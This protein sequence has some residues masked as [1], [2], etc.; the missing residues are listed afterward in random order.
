MSLLESIQSP[1]DLKRLSDDQLQTLCG[2]IRQQLLVTVADTGGH[3]ASNLGVVELTVALLAVFDFPDDKL[4][5]DVGHQAYVYKL[6]TGRQQAMAQLRQTGGA[7][8]FPVRSESPYDAFG[9]GHAGTAVS[10]ALGMAA[11]RDRQGSKERI[12]A[13]V[14]DG[15]LG[16]GSTLEG[17]NSTVEVTRDLVVILN[18]NKMSIG[19]NVGALSKHLNALLSDSSYYRARN[20]F[21]DAV[22]AIPGVGHRLKR[23]FANLYLAIKNSVLPPARV[24][25]EFGFRYLGPIDGHDLKQLLKTFRNLRDLRDT[26]LLL[27]VMTQ[28]GAGYDPAEDDP[29]AFH[30]TGSF[31]LETGA[32]RGGGGA[33][34]FSKEFGNS[35]ERLLESNPKV[36]AITAGTCLGTGLKSVRERHPKQLFDVGI[37]EEHAVIFAAG[38]ATRGFVPVVAIYATFMHRAMDYVFHDVCLQNLPVVLCLDRA[39]FVEDGPTHHGIHDLGFWRS[40]PNLAVLQPADQAELD[41]M[42]VLAVASGRPVLIRYPKAEATLLPRQTPVAW[43]RAALIREGGDLAIWASGRETVLALEVASRLAETGIEAAVVN[44][45]FLRP[46]DAELARELAR[47]QPLV[48]LENHVVQGG[49]AECL[50]EAVADLPGTRL[51][52]RGWPLEIIPHGSE[53]EMRRRYRLDAESLAADIAAFVTDRTIGH[54]PAGPGGRRTE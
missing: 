30:G 39:G 4:L 28:K 8:G 21:R 7:C 2:E 25:Q 38:L 16:C 26:P 32:A 47:K 31:C 51:L 29:E 27:H 50:R 12:F 5:F 42:L 49:L 44:P 43:G 9:A 10:A 41:A 23:F 14:G 1:A 36:V 18:D 22:E 54:A 19:P 6:L 40:I 37:A 20:R 24:F 13:L 3:L 15:A 48:S 52:A 35:L 33:P 11:A 34:S 53:T 45:R 46:F 17:L